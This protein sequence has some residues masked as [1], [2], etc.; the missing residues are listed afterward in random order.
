MAD[1]EKKETSGE[2]SEKTQEASSKKKLTLLIAAIVLSFILSAA[3]NFIYLKMTY[4]TPESADSL[5]A[6]GYQDEYANGPVLEIKLDDD[7]VETSYEAPEETITDTVELVEQAQETYE[8]SIKQVITKLTSSMASRDSLL[9]ATL[10]ELQQVKKQLKLEEAY[11]DSVSEKKGLKLAKIIENMPPKDA[12]AM[13]APLEDD[14]ILDV[15]MRLKQR[16]AAKIMAEFSASRS[17]QLSE[18]ILKP[19]VNG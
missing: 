13:L 12:A 17:S 4:V 14:L 11:E 9:N 2:I 10:I 1:E 19:V 7:P 5:N 3:G 18:R 16:Q 6:D 15:L 8:D